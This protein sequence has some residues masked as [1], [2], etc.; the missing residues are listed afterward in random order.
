MS[1]PTSTYVDLRGI[2]TQFSKRQSRLFTIWSKKIIIFT[3][4][5]KNSTS[6]INRN[7][8]MNLIPSIVRQFSIITRRIN[9]K[10]MLTLDM[11]IRV[12]LTS[13]YTWWKIFFRFVLL[14]PPK[15]IPFDGKINCGFQEVSA[16]HMQ[17]KWCQISPKI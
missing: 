14:P 9:L 15:V 5:D 12:V 3:Q 10:S 11:S 16:S 1:Q 13:I 4:R 2:S 6:K 17:D 7:T 8:S